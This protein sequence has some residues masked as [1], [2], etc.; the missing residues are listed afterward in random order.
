MFHYTRPSFNTMLPPNAVDGL[1]AGSQRHV[2]QQD[3]IRV[4][5]GGGKEHTKLL[6]QPKQKK[7][8]LVT[9]RAPTRPT[10]PKKRKRKKVA[11][12]KK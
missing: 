12:R 1:F 7:D 3:D 5:P 2:L 10:K 8:D 11:R 6:K 9:T 4:Q